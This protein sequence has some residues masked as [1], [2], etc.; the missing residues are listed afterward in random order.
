MGVK[1]ERKL[2]ASSRRVCHRVPLIYNFFFHH[3]AQSS[4]FTV[5]GAVGSL[6]VASR[7]LGGDPR[8]GFLNVGRC[9]HACNSLMEDSGACS[10]S[11]GQFHSNPLCDRY[12]VHPNFGPCLPRHGTFAGTQVLESFTVF[13]KARGAWL[14]TAQYRA[15]VPQVLMPRNKAAAQPGATS[16]VGK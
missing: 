11:S 15:C 4:D 1:K 14:T 10:H 8:G 2:L 13:Q 7:L 12:T 16:A 9:H 3:H 5:P 6:A